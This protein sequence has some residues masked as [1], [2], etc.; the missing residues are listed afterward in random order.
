MCFFFISIIFNS[1]DIGFRC[2]SDIIG[3]DI[4]RF[5]EDTSIEI[6]VLCIGDKEDIKA[7]SGKIFLKQI[8]SL[9]ISNIFIYLCINCNNNK[10]IMYFVLTVLIFFM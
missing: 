7:S 1:F 4:E 2:K 5:P 9:V 10:R 3:M 6:Q 8:R